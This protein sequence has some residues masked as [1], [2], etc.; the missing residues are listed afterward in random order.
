[1]P[2]RRVC[3]SLLRVCNLLRTRRRADICEKRS[4]PW[5]QALRNSMH[6]LGNG[7]SD[8][9]RSYESS[10]VREVVGKLMSHFK[11]FAIFAVVLAL[12]SAA[13]VARAAQF[14]LNVDFCSNP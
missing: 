8:A 5:F 4:V 10:L 11:L 14:D 3:P 7:C 12:I 9:N 13:P 2:A 6:G 1:M